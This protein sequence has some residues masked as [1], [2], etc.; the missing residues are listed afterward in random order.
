MGLVRVK[1]T[2]GD[3]KRAKVVE[4]MIIADSAAF[5]TIIP[6]SLAQELN[7]QV[8]TTTQVTLADGRKA[9][10]AVSVAYV[11]LLDREGEF[12]VWIMASPEPLLGTTVFE[13][14]GLVIDPST[15]EVRHSRGF[16][17]AAL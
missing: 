11:K 8:L 2:I 5:N 16:G 17:L 10:A 9:S 6:P 7:L 15:G 4:K 3:P 13:G 1:A 12:I 14:L